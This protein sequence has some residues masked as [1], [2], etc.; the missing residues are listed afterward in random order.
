MIHKANFE[1]ENYNIRDNELS[2]FQNFYDYDDES[3]GMQQP[4]LNFN[5]IVHPSFEIE[6]SKYHFL[7]NEIDEEYGQDEYVRQYGDPWTNLN[8]YM[9]DE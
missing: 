9:Y 1:D 3:S 5:R 4:S 8:I 6:I 7:D 2:E